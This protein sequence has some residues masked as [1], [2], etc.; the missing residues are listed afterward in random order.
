MSAN[1]QPGE[2]KPGQLEGDLR[3]VLRKLHYSLKTEESYIGWYR[4]F[5]LWHGK[6]HPRD[7]GAAADNTRG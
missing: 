6:R 7:M 3:G 4:R 5:I 2:P 1:R